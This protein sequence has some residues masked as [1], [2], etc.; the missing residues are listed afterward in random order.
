MSK[1]KFTHSVALNITI[2]SDNETPSKEET[3]KAFKKAV[4]ALNESNILESTELFDTEE[5]E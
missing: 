2:Q 5:N 1:R 3:L 4:E